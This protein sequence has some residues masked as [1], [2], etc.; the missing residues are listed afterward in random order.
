MP[1]P[2]ASYPSPLITNA[3]EILK[4]GIVLKQFNGGHGVTA[5]PYLLLIPLATSHSSLAT[6]KENTDQSIS[7]PSRGG[8]CHTH[9]RLRLP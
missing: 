2:L 5:L 1:R 9:C 6:K 4:I 3:L 8:N 7:V